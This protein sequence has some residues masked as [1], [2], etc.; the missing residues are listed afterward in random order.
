M[1]EDKGTLDVDEDFIVGHGEAETSTGRHSHTHHVLRRL[2]QDRRPQRHTRRTH[3]DHRRRPDVR[4]RATRPGPEQDPPLLCRRVRPL[5]HQQPA[6]PGLV[7][8][9]WYPPALHAP[10]SADTDTGYT[11]LGIDYFF[12]DRF[13]TL[14]QQPDFVRET[15]RDKVVAQAGE[16]TPKWVEAV[17]QRYGQK[18]PPPR[19][20]ADVGSGTADV[21]YFAVGT[22]SFAP[23]SIYSHRAGYCFGAPY[24]FSLANDPTFNLAAGPS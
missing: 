22:P 18:P 9:Q 20:C 6:R 3:G 12:G 16:F 19:V 17:R 8:I 13:E 1:E 4:L 7:C 14:G 23:S 2:L 24:V 10:D 11:V 5:L 21:K 15:W